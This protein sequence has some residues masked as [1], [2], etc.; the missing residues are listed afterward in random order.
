MRKRR[1]DELG[2][3]WWSPIEIHLAT[4]G[5]AEQYF[6]HARKVVRIA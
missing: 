5:E 6:K 4:R 1:A 2:V 3:P